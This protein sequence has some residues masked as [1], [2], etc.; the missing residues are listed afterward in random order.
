MGRRVKD[1]ALNPDQFDALKNLADSSMG[2]YEQVGTDGPH[3]RLRELV[4]D[5][6][7]TCPC[8]AGYRGQAGELWYVR[9]LPPAPARP[10]PLLHRFYDAVS[11]LLAGKGDWVQ[12]L[13]QQLMPHRG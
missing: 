11:I 13:Q 4:T 2:V 3:V 6:E 8:A 7:F 10:G 12:F 1:R 5:A 9:F